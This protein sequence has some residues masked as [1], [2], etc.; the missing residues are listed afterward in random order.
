MLEHN[1]SQRYS[2]LRWAVL[3]ACCMAGACFQLAA[4]SYAPLLGEIAK[5][6]S[7]D[8]SQSLQLMTYF[9]FFS[10][11]SFFIG[12]YFSDRFGAPASIIVS[13]LLASVP[14]FCTIW[15]DHSYYAVVV[16][17]I[18]QGFSVGFCMTGMIPLVMQWFPMHQRPFALGITGAFIP[19]GAMLGMVVTPAAFS[20]YGDWK[21]AM[22]MI[23][24]IPFFALVYS[25]FIFSYTHGKAPQ[26]NHDK[27]SNESSNDMFKAAI[28]SPY[29]WLGILVVFASNWIIQTAFSLTPSYFAEPPQVGLGMGPLVGGS[30]TTI[31][32]T[33][34]II[35][36]IIGGYIAGHIFGGRPGNIIVTAFILV[37]TYGAIQFSAVYQHQTLL[38]LFLIIPGLGV[39]MLM[40]ML[41]AKIAES[42]DPSIIGRM[43]G[44]WMGVGSFG[45]TVGLFV[46]AKALDATGTYVTA[47]NILSAIALIGALSGYILNRINQGSAA[48]LKKLSIS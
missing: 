7:V 16:I 29:T 6:L 33:A 38:T 32:Q 37:C 10:T 2:A 18:L 41:Q 45:G 47:I 40:P 22:M 34:S 43:N 39:G 9:M 35:A 36:P 27:P 23:S 42:Y 24:I 3:A 17:R 21:S 25:L 12:G 30:M 28:A 11:I 44:V 48:R 20:V 19:L 5:D 31:L 15:V 4:M 13:F 26:M 1:D 14:T 8:L 46:A